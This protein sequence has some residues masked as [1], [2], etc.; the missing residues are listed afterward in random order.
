M[1]SG[2]PAARA[3]IGELDAVEAAIDMELVAAF[4]E[5]DEESFYPLMVTD[6][7]A[8]PFER[9]R[10]PVVDGR[11]PDRDAPVRGRA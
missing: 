9:M 2:D 10:A 1:A 7:G 3:A 8:L 11:F 6:G 4:P 5:A